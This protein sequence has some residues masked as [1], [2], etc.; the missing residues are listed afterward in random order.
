MAIK[1]LS[2][3]SQLKILS[4]NVIVMCNLYEKVAANITSLNTGPVEQGKHFSLYSYYQGV[5]EQTNETKGAL[6]KH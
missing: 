2:C 6:E 4:C 3:Q 5:Q 1:H